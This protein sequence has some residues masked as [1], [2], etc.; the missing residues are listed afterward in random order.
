MRGTP[1]NTNNFLYRVL[2]EAGKKAGVG[3]VTHHLSESLDHLLKS[4]SE[5]VEGGQLNPMGPNFLSAL[6]VSY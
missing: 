5:A 2:K 6:L 3:H 4:K 1:I